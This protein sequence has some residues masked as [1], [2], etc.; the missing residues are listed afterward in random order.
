MRVISGRS[1]RSSLI[2]PS[3]LKRPRAPASATL[4]RLCYKRAVF[5][6]SRRA[7]PEAGLLTITPEAVLQAADELLSEETVV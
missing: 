7:E 3:G 5:D 2:A 4:P 6:H 1:W